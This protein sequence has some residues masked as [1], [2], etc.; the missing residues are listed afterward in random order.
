GAPIDAPKS[1][2]ALCRDVAAGDHDSAADW[3]SCTPNPGV[4]AAGSDDPRSDPKPAPEPIAPGALQIVEVLANPLGPASGEKALEFIEVLNLS[5]VELELSGCRVG[6]DV[7][8]DAPGVAPLA[9]LSG[10]G[11]CASPTCL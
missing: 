6:D 5:D 8:V 3:S 10:D 11:G 7:S 1:G 9:W 4:L 2:A